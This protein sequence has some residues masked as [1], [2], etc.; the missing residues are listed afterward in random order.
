[1]KGSE[2]KMIEYME[3]AGKRY[4]IPV[5]QR[6]YDWKEENCRQLY[7]DLKKIVLDNRD[8]HFFG[9]IVSSVIGNGAS[10]E[11]HIIDGQQRITTVSLLLLAIR[12]LIRQKKIS[13][14]ENRLDDQINDRFLVSPWAKEDDQIKLRPVKGDREALAKLFGE[15]EDYD[16]TSNLTLNYRFFCDQIVKGEVSVDDLYAAIGKL[17]IIS[18]TLDRGDNAQLIFESLNSTGLALT[19]GDKIRN[20]ILMGQSPKVQNKLYDTYWTIIERCTG[21]DV[22]GFVRDYLSIKQQVTPTISNVYRAFK[23]FA[24]KAQIPVEALLDDLRRY[25]RFFEKLRICKSGLNDKK[26]DDCL[27]RMAR[28][29]I[30]VTRPFLMEVLRLNQD[31]KLLVDDVLRIFLI[32][33]NYLFRRNICEVP[34]NALNKI[35][36]NLNKEILSYDNTADNYVQKFIYALLS[37]KESGRFPD[38]EEFTTALAAK[39]VYQMRGKYKAYLFERFENFGTIETKDVYTHLDNNVYTIEHIMPQHLSP[40]WMES[41]GANAAEIHTVWLHRLANLTLTGY[42]PN[43]SNK[44][45][46]EK[47]DSKEGG[48]K[49]SGLK[50]N[51]KISNKESWGLSELKERNDEMIALAK[52][53][54]VYPQTAFVPS[55]KE[56]DSCTLD[57]E[58]VD[59]TG[60]DIV[61]YGYLSVEQPVSSWADMFEHVV[62]FLHQKDKSVLSGLAYNAGASM[63]LA[64]YVSN[65]SEGL[66]NALKVDDN[67]YMKRI[68]STTLKLSVLRR[69]FVLYNADPMD[70]VFYLNDTERE[71]VTEASRFEIRKRYWM[72]ALPI[73]QKQHAHRG[74]F[75]NCNPVTSNTESGFFGISGFCIS[76]IANY[77]SARIDFY[78]GK[79]DAAENKAAF[80][81]LRSHKDEIE[82]DL[83]ISLT[84]ERADEYKASWLCYYLH[85]VSIT[86]ENDWPRMA[87]FHAEWSDRICTVVLPYLQTE[88]DTTARLTNIA[89]ILRKWT[90]EREGVNA[91]LAKCNR[92]Y[93]RFTTDGMKKILPDLPDA[94]SGWNTDNHYFYEIVN[95]TGKSVYIKFAISSRNITDEFRAICDRI[96]EFYPAKF[97]KEDWQW[98]VPF[99]TT[100]IEIDEALSK[101]AI[102]ARLDECLNEIIAFEQDLKHKLEL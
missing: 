56:F 43:L 26:L 71:K 2:S 28:L 3:G 98:R 72:Y 44:T 97:G 73:I 12:N 6:K 18:I 67:I 8:S 9:S 69:L 94:P 38:D 36:L 20:Y 34:T 14:Q 5:Y 85:D 48:Y 51:Q 88:D 40:A 1:M 52:K 61:K 25:A 49:A 11:Y 53:I 45:F 62:K 10:T 7:E 60:R 19:E 21:N 39:Q 68:T 23:V 58:N 91:N 82:E 64:N 65:T 15:E 66:R 35:F 76:C 87:K 84:W 13:A 46:A 31:G 100:A 41:L 89:G 32:T 54:W 24:E 16:P 55:E 102:F 78:M 50:M 77:D 57:D 33:E 83:G 93:T 86:N 81:L 90:V 42:N 79:S 30:V 99:K 59:L 29:E 70:L 95:R 22:S 101:E 37:K 47:R 74:T 80:D 17:E 27:Y 96:N 63:D 4:V 75:S 92:T